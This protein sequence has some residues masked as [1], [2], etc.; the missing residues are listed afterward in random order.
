MVCLVSGSPPVFCLVLF[1]I[2]LSC[3]VYGAGFDPP[4]SLT[5]WC[6]SS[7][8]WICL[9]RLLSSGIALTLLRA[10]HSPQTQKNLPDALFGR[11]PWYFSSRVPRRSTQG[12]VAVSPSWLLSFGSTPERTPFYSFFSGCAT[13]PFLSPVHCGSTL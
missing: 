5:C 11:R 3:T 10:S 2:C 1:C 13:H 8:R 9:G 4:V 12:C 6:T 7:L